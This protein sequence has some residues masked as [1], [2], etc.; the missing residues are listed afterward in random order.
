MLVDDEPVGYLCVERGARRFAL[1]DIALLPAHCGRGVGSEVVG[2]FLREATE[3]G[4][5]VI[6]HVEK[7]S[8][9]WQLWQR[10][11]FDVTDDDGVH[12]AIERRV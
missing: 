3:A 5:P 12:L 8:R 10:L 9:A 11:G 6:A 7:D 2:A 1:V 4:K